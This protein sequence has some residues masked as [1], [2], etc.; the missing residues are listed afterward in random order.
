MGIALG[1]YA[2]LACTCSF[3]FFHYQNLRSELSKT[4]HELSFRT[5]EISTG[6]HT[7]ECL[8][9]DVTRLEQALAEK[10][11]NMQYVCGQT[12]SCE[13]LVRML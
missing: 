6:Q 9:S 3:L 8:Q 2:E 12:G 1:L 11:T 5:D 4:Q 7:Q 10:D 13:C